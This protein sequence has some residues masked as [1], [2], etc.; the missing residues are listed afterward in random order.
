MCHFWLLCL[1]WGNRYENILWALAQSFSW[2]LSDIIAS[3]QAPL[4]LQES[5]HLLYMLPSVTDLLFPKCTLESS[6]LLAQC[7]PGQKRKFF[8]Y[9]VGWT[10][11]SSRRSELQSWR[12]TMLNNLSF[13]RY[14]PSYLGYH[15]GF[16]YVL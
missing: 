6:C 16:P 15:I 11:F 7:W 4:S 3:V 13:L 14:S 5:S 9:L 1:A 10:T 2:P 12:G 8:C